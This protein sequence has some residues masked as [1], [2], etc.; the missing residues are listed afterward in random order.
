MEKVYV[1]NMGYYGE[2]SY[3]CGSNDII[4]VCSTLEG[5]LKVFRKVIIDEL[6]E[7]EERII[8]EWE[9]TIKTKNNLQDIKKLIDVARQKVQENGQYYVCEYINEDY[10]NDG[11]DSAIIEIKEVELD[12]WVF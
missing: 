4:G 5:A 7:D 9:K 11:N 6:F 1:V 2:W 12:K 8:D 3:D 10:Y